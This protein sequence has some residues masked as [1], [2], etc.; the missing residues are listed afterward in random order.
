MAGYA[1][2]HVKVEVGFNYPWAWNKYGLYFG[3]GNPP[4]SDAALDGWTAALAGNLGLLRERLGI[5]KVRIFLLCSAVNLGTATRTGCR[6]TY[7]APR[8]LHPRFT[9]HLVRMLKAF[10]DCKMQVIPSL[11]DFGAFLSKPSWESRRAIAADPGEGARFMDTVLEPLLDASEGEYRNS[12][13]AWEVM[14]E[15]VWATADIRACA[16]RM[17]DRPLARRDMRAF[18]GGALARIERRGFPSTVGH[19]FAGDLSRFPTGSIRQFHYYPNRGLLG[20][21]AE[22]ALPPF[23]ETQAILGEFASELVPPASRLGV[24]WPEIERG[25]QEETASRVAAR[26]QLI[27]EKGYRLT[28]V[29]PDLDGTKLPDG[30]AAHPGGDDPLKL[31]AGAQEGIR[32]YQSRRP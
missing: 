19:R 7:D 30:T 16:A 27:E 5:E 23:R 24:P 9:E 6:W 22:R 2:R 31:S 20:L 26:L 21:Y 11:L 13:Y 28:F 8:A 3:A 4:G 25:A 29:W 14:N 15:P 12:I 18:L 17:S 10:H 1:H 32:R